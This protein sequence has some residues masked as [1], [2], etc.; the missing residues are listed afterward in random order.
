MYRKRVLRESMM[1]TV[2]FVTPW[3]EEQG[4]HWS[5]GVASRLLP[6]VEAVLKQQTSTRLA[7]SA[8]Q[9]VQRVL[10]LVLDRLGTEMHPE[11]N[12]EVSLRDAEAQQVCWTTL[13][14]IHQA[15]LQLMPDGIPSQEV[16][17]DAECHQLLT[18]IK[19]LLNPFIVPVSS[20]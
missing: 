14:S 17:N 20:V 16:E 12:G 18:S 13:H 10:V 15:V 3:Q 8:L 4:S 1:D 11:K 2:T 7:A 9:T 5:L 19:A 6:Q